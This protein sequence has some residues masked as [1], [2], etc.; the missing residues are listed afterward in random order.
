M[1]MR[2]ITLKSLHNTKT[3]HENGVI[4]A[5]CEISGASSLSV[6]SAGPGLTATKRTGGRRRALAGFPARRRGRRGPGRGGRAGGTGP[7][8]RART[9]PRSGGQ[10]GGDRPEKQEASRAGGTGPRSGRPAGRDGPERR[11]SAGRD[12]SDDLVG[13]EF[14]EVAGGL[15][16]RA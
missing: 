9:G 4:S 3:L 10:P 15:G 8:S 5:M 16:D 14:H 7:S 11:G 6:V 12:G 1:V 13:G 2:A